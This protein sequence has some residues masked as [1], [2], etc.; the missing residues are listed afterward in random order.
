MTETEHRA[1]GD[2]AYELELIRQ[3]TESQEQD[4][5]FTTDIGPFLTL[6]CCS[7]T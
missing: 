4:P 1:E 3:M 6:L 7:V 5:A 2:L